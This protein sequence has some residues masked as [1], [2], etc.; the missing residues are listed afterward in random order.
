[1]AMR[2][3]T[4]DGTIIG[5]GIGVL[6]WFFDYRHLLLG[7][8]PHT[9]LT[10]A[11]NGLLTFGPEPLLESVC[12]LGHQGVNIVCVNVSVLFIFTAVGLIAGGLAARLWRLVR[13]RE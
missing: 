11:L 6:V 5:G 12:N 8:V 1:M 2:A 7:G 13:H 3:D 10:D 4:R 9:S